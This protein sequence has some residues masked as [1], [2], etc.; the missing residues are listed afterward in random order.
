MSRIGEFG[1]EVVRRVGLID[2]ETDKNMVAL[3]AGVS[4][5]VLAETIKPDNTLIEVIALLKDAYNDSEDWK[6]PS[7]VTAVRKKIGEAIDK[8]SYK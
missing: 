7:N 5:G 2:N 1:E 8:L 3:I 6:N 4:L